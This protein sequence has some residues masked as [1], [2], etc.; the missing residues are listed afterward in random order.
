MFH[1]A[2][3]EERVS[4]LQSAGNY[5]KTVI[6]MTQKSILRTLFLFRPHK[7]PKSQKNN[8]W[9][10]LFLHLNEKE[11]THLTQIVNKNVSC[12]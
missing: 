8:E 6:G 5:E 10:L 1:G 4:V 7:S 2:H 9:H 3:Y 11:D 12:F